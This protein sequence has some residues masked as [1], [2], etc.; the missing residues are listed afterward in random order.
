VKETGSYDYSVGISRKWAKKAQLAIPKMRN[1]GWDKNAIDY[2]D[3]IAQYMVERE[4]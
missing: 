1:K 4:V 3:G 2:L